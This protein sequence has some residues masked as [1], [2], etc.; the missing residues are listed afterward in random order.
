MPSRLTG[1]GAVCG[2]R[3]MTGDPA[4]TRRPQKTNF[5]MGLCMQGGDSHRAYLHLLCISRE[6]QKMLNKSKTRCTGVTRLRA[7][8]V[9]LAAA[10][11]TLATPAIALAGTVST[12]DPFYSFTETLQAW[13]SGGLGVGLAF[14]SVAMGAITAVATHKHIMALGGVALAAFIHWGPPIIMSLITAGA[15]LR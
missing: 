10:S 11:A 4:W 2:G 7:R 5:P 12:T 13:L 14:A 3:R 6:T 1:S 9:S 15:V 8:L